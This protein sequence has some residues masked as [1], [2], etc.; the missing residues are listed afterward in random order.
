MLRMM[1]S[2]AAPICPWGASGVWKNMEIAVE[3]RQEHK[4]KGGEKSKKK[5]R[6]RSE[7]KRAWASLEKAPDEVIDEML[8]EASPL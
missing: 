2:T 1:K 7:N 5:S 4:D 6:P 3:V 8:C